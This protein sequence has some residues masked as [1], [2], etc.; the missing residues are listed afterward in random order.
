MAAFRYFSGDRELR[1]VSHDGSARTLPQNFSGFP[2]GVEPA[3]VAGIGWTGR[4]TADRRV[5]YKANP[6]RHECDDRCLNAT[7]RT[8]K[9]ECAC[10]G[11]N[12][13]RGS[14]MCEAA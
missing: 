4:V 9:C 7:G 6:S 11:K 13:G 3:F 8:M 5:E 10:G 14:F 2:Q 1:N 12:H